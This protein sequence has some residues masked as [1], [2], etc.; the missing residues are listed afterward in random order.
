MKHVARIFL[1]F[2]HF[3]II[4]LYKGSII[5]PFY[6]QESYRELLKIIVGKK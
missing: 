3:I 4:S 5:K 1:T 6:F 2:V